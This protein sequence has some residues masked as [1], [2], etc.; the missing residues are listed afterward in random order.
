[1]IFAFAALGVAVGL[2]QFYFLKKTVEKVTCGD[3]VFLVFILIKITMYALS[4]AILLMLFPE[5]IIPAGIGFAAGIIAGSVINF[6]VSSKS[7]KKGDDTA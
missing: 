5:Y 1:M 6:I 7:N 2:F 4:I 3:K